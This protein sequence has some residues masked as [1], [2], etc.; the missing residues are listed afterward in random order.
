[1]MNTT[2]IKA[3]WRALPLAKEN[4]FDALDAQIAR[5][6]K[7]WEA[8]AH[9]LKERDLSTL[10]LG[11]NEIGEG[12]FANV[13]EYET[14]LSNVFELHRRYIDVQ[15]LAWGEETV[16]V[17]PKEQAQEPQGEFDE[18][19]DFILYARADK[20]QP[21]LVSPASYQVF[22]PTDAHKP[23]MATNGVPAPV[24]KICVKIPVA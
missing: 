2:D 10:P 11:R 5:S 16:F 9:F 1:M 13:A 12:C 20:V 15:L 22:F 3:M 17:A 7:A 4:D 8:V 23:C 14:K 21:R 6:P 24:R 18:T 19:N